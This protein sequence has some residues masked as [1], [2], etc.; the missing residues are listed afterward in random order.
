MS[1]GHILPKG[2]RIGFPSFA[3]HTD[4]K[5]TTYAPE[6]NPPVYTS[7]EEFGGMRFYKLRNMPGKETCH[8]L[9]TA[10]PES[11]AFGYGNHTCPE[12]F[13]A[14]N[15]IKIILVELLMNWGSRLKGDVEQK[16]GP[17]KRP[18]NMEVDLV[19]TPNPT[20]M[21]ELKRRRGA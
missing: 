5:T 15:E 14:S 2:T 1:T 10:G 4:P 9:A 19:M 7:P 16:G 20:A 13:F 17:E 3:V 12:R 6:Y 11:L 18:Q 8:Q 21:V